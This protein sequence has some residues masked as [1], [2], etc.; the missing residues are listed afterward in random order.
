VKELG[1]KLKKMNS[2]VL[3][4]YKGLPAGM[5]DSLR[6]ELKTGQAEMEVVKNSLAK[7][8]FKDLGLAG[9]EKMLAGQVA[10][11]HGADP[12]STAKKL[13]G[14]KEKNKKLEIR[15]GFFG[16]DVLTPDQ[17]KVLSQ[18]PSRE[19]LL[20]Q[21]AGLIAAPMSDFAGC[22][23]A[24]LQDTAGLIQALEEKKSK[25]GAAPASA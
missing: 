4:D 1:G 21:I 23:G 24:L 16:K 10:L 20:S 25:E 15:G 22:L 8:A 7:L 6:K 12:A 14:W 9:L 2:A 17:I 18:L 5:A 3:I 11:V 13:L 19:A